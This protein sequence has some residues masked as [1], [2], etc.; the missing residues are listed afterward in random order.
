MISI[1]GISFY[2]GSRP[3]YKDA[4]LHISD[5]EK[6][7]LI[8]KNGTG[9]STLLKILYGEFQLES[10][11]IEMSKDTSIGYFHQDLLS[12]TEDK[13]I[14]E[15]V[16]SAFGNLLKQQKEIDSILEKLETDYSEDLLIRLNELQD[17]FNTMGGYSM[18]ASA[19]GVLAGLGF[20]NE[21]MDRKI[22]TFSGGWRMRVL[23]AKMLLQRPNLLMLDE[24]TNH[25]DLPSIEWLED[26]LS[27]YP[28]SVIVV[29][30]DQ[31]FIN[32]V[33]DVIVEVAFQKLTRFPGNYDN[34]LIQKSE[35]SE[36]QMNAFQNQQKKI[37]DTEK[38]INRFRAKATKA[39]QVQSRVKALDKM[40][41]VD[42][43][44]E[45]TQK[46]SI[47]FP[48]KV[49]PGKDILDLNLKEKR[50]GDN[51]VLHNSHLNIIRGQKIA[52]IGANGKGKSTLLRILT[53]T[54]IF[55]GHR[56][57]GHN[58]NMEFYAQHQLEALNLKNDIISEMQQAGLQKTDLE[59][60]TLLGA[61]LFTGDD[62]FKKIKVLSGGEKSRVALAKTLLGEANFLLLDEPTNHLDLDSTEILIE[63]LK[64]Y[65]G[66]FI[67][68]SH[69]RHFIS[70][71]ANEIWYIED[72]VIKSYPGDYKE[73]LGYAEKRERLKSDKK[74]KKVESKSKKEKPKSP[75]IK[76]APETTK[77]IK[78]LEESIEKHEQNISEIEKKLS[79]PEIM[80]N[81]DEF[82]QLL[83][84]H[85]AESEELELK[86][87][88]WENYIS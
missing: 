37:K 40:D 32:N 51:L 31:D 48:V 30:H 18:E 15:I 21:E 62:I 49:Q 46:I 75:S 36:I 84:K 54:E 6:I 65:K 35:R 44:E 57:L 52:L 63:A 33:A 2:F 25:L 1:N 83:K 12:Q 13:S 73:Y 78:D 74:S 14:K 43:P 41:I 56:K 16:L 23:L 8:G 70:A 69:N 24:P 72:K 87:N 79:L 45:D 50:Y 38:F 27:S 11:S 53:G 59:I 5:G 60:R 3:I 29:S 20:S 86:M 81:K 55:E 88:E 42:A 26:Y 4:S 28:G 39:K 67:I 77:A 80:E 10:G 47:D 68:V 34:Y 76:A 64:S 22:E 58:V 7:G 85:Q 17:H 66:T 82:N 9:K 61:F 19:E 71:V